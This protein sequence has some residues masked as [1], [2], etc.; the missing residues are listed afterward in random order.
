MTDTAPAEG[1]SR[2][3]ASGRRSGRRM[4]TPQLAAATAA[5][6][7]ALFLASMMIP[8]SFTVA[9]LRLSPIRVVMLLAFIPLMVRLVA[10]RAGR[11]NV[12]DVLMIAHCLWMLLAST[13]VMG[14]ERL[15]YIS[16]T[17]VE[18]LGG[19]LVGRTLI[20]SEIDYRTFFRYFLWTLAFMLPFGLVEFLTTRQPLNDLVDLVADTYRRGDST[21]ARWGLMRAQGSFE[22]PILFG[23]YCSIAFAHVFYLYRDSIAKRLTLMP[24]VGF[25]TFMSLS[26]APFLSVAMQMGMIVWD[27][28]TRSRWWLLFGLTVAAYIV[29]DMLS[30]RTP[31]T[32]LINYVPFDAHTAWTRVVQW[33][34]GVRNLMQSPIFG[35]GISFEWERPSWLVNSVDNFWLVVA[36]RYGIPGIGLLLATIAFAIWRVIRARN[37]AEGEEN[38]RTAYMVALVGLLFALATVHIWGAVAVLTMFF[39]GA[40]QWLASVGESRAAPAEAPAEES[41]RRAGRGAFR[42][43][44]QPPARAGRTTRPGPALGRRRARRT[45]DPPSPEDGV[46]PPRPGRR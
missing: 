2:S 46:R 28:A 29:V 19:Y 12:V 16:M 31:I 40:G 36:M 18:L 20:L 42:A 34:W 41:L 9:G 10:G 24:F 44:P 32:I 37:L 23:L 45:G 39:I 30:N 15:P 38:C 3:R 33:D 26:S 6:F 27:K 17:I 35:L 8:M 5:A 22:H 1:L 7:L 14:F 11:I 4:E 43:R 21:R 13:V 25:M